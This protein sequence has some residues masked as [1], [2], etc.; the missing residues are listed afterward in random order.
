M[1]SD[2]TPVLAADL[3]NINTFL[4]IPRFR[5]SI[6]GTGQIG[7]GCR[8]GLFCRVAEPGRVAS[9]RKTALSRKRARRPAEDR[10]G[11]LILAAAPGG[12]KVQHT[13]SRIVITTEPVKRG[14]DAH[15]GLR[16][17]AYKS[18]SSLH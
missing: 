18:I 1:T 3:K 6:S 8:V 12:V 2:M 15:W 5:F 10:H 4:A 14:R 11:R 9:Q 7:S 17:D 13:M 16:G